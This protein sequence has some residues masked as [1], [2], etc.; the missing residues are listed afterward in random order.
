MD[1]SVLGPPGK[2][3]EPNADRRGSRRYLPRVWPLGFGLQ[4]LGP[5]PGQFDSRGALAAPAVPKPPD[6]T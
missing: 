3:G 6:L 2:Y 5:K 4:P 1:S